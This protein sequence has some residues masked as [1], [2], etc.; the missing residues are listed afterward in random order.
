MTSSKLGVVA[1]PAFPSTQRQRQE[2]LKFRVRPGIQKEFKPA[3]VSRNQAG[4]TNKKQ[5]VP[6]LV[7][8]YIK[9]HL[10][11]FLKFLLKLL[12]FKLWQPYLTD[13]HASDQNCLATSACIWSK[14]LGMGTC[15]WSKCM[16]TG[17]CIW[18]KYLA[19][20]ECI[21]CSKCQTRGWKFT[22]SWYYRR[23]L[24][25]VQRLGNSSEYPLVCFKL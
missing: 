21:C 14:F 6:K 17:A 25:S 24:S 4:P 13:V 19:I 2:A 20:N 11:F 1:S 23:L 10:L 22:A 16:T 18:S 7:Y 9:M 15:I 3:W 5:M 12:Y 8:L